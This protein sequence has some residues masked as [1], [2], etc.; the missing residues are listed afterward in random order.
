MT[1]LYAREGTK[2]VTKAEEGGAEQ[3]VKSDFLNLQITSRCYWYILS[4]DS[5]KVVLTF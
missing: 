3:V 4:G 1:E 2:I 5:Q